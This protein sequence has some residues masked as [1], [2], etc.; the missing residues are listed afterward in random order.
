MNW[1][2][3]QIETRKGYLLSIPNSTVSQSDIHNFSYPDNQYRLR[4]TVPIAI[5]HDP[6][7]VEEIFINAVLSV[8]EV[9]KDFKLVIWLKD[10]QTEAGKEEWAAIYVVVFETKIYHRRFRILK[11]VWDKIWVHLNQ[12]G[13]FHK[14]S[15][16]KI[17]E[18]SQE[19]SQ[20]ATSPIEFKLD[21]VFKSDNLQKMMVNSTR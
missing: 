7:K 5:N 20:S 14:L 1:R 15:D 11:Q 13:I 16:Y 8:E 6:R 18:D 10:V 17:D 4:L 21:K 2:V 3:T 19:S 12:N 9:I